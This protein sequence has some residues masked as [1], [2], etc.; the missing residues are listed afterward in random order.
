M[1]LKKFL[2]LQIISSF[3]KDGAEF[4][5]Y[6]LQFLFFWNNFRERRPRQQRYHCYTIVNHKSIIKILF[7]FYFLY[8]LDLVI[9]LLRVN[10]GRNLSYSNTDVMPLQKHD[11]FLNQI[12]SGYLGYAFISRLLKTWFRYDI[13]F[14]KTGVIA[15]V[16]SENITI[17]I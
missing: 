9:S 17:L 3:T 14:A 16:Q 7:Y 15:S 11:A 6:F 10:M 12:S 2:E 5:N 1:F 8:P 13:G 4:L